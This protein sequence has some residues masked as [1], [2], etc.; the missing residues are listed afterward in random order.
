MLGLPGLYQNWLLATL[1][2]HSDF[3]LQNEN[4]FSCNQS[5]VKLAMKIQTDLSN[6]TFLH[7]TVI[8]TYVSDQNFVWFLYNFLE[9]TDGVNIRVD[10]LIEDLETKAPGTIAFDSILKHWSD[11][12]NLAHHP[13]YQYRLNSAIEYFY[14]LLLD[15]QGN[16]KHL[17]GFTDPRFVNIE[18]ANFENKK[19]LENKLSHLEIFDLNHFNR[20]YDLLHQRNIRY[21]TRRHNFVSKIQSNNKNF[22]ILELAYIGMLITDQDP[23]DWFNTQL[24]ESIIN[25]RWSDIC[26]H[27]N[28]LL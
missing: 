24:R 19:L 16:F 20:M 23:I 13:D 25:D 10:Y 2:Q 3:K 18:Y 17:V 8:N 9:K 5:R 27:A 11:S 26:D 7:S 15:T 14:F 1:D 22:D 28:N 21:L 6:I 12:Y 4:N